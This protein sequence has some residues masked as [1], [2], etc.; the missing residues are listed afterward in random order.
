MNDKKYFLKDDIKP[1]SLRERKKR[2]AEIDI[3]EAALHLFQQNGYEQTSIKDIADA[4]MMSPRTFFRYFSSK[5]EVLTRFFRTTKKDVT[6]SIEQVAPTESPHTALRVVFRSLASK[7]QKQRSNFLIRY[8][9]A[10]QATSISSLFLYTL[11]ESEPDI[12]DALCSHLEDTDLNDVHFLVAIYMTAF[13]VS[14]EKWVKN[15]KLS[16]LVSLLN[17]HMDAIQHISVENNRTR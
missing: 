10:L 4:V 3:E 12:C 2:Q 17:D 1:F 16:D 7:Y 15:E 6:H 14:I 8:D 11:L 5:E 9:V 13:R